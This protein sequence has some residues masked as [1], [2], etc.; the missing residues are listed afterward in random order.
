MSR[1]SR[2]QTSSR[3]SFTGLFLFAR[4]HNNNPTFIFIF[5]TLFLLF[6]SKHV[7]QFPNQLKASTTTPLTMGKQGPSQSLSSRTKER[8]TGRQAGSS[9][10]SGKPGA[11]DPLRLNKF[12][13]GA[14]YYTQERGESAGGG[15]GAGGQGST[16]LYADRVSGRQSQG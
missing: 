14:R 1:G 6:F 12:I 16:S 3:V 5:F 11:V 8:S 15:G 10:S 2:V 9:G 13:D 4:L 7:P